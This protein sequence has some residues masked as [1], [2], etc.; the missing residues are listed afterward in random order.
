MR[1]TRAAERGERPQEER[2]HRLSH[3][4]T[5]ARVAAD[6]RD[7]DG[8]IMWNRR[9]SLDEALEV[10]GLPAGTPPQEALRVA[11]AQ[12]AELDA[13]AHDQADVLRMLNKAEFWLQE[14]E[15]AITGARVLIRVLLPDV[16]VEH[17]LVDGPSSSDWQEEILVVAPLWTKGHREPDRAH[18]ALAE[19]RTAASDRGLEWLPAEVE[20]SDGLR[21]ALALP[22]VAT[23]DLPPPLLHNAL[24]VRCS[25]E[26]AVVDLPRGDRWPFA[27]R[28]VKSGGQPDPHLV[29]LAD[30]Q[31]RAR[32]LREA[33]ARMAEERRQA[34]EVQARKKAERARLREQQEALL[35]HEGWPSGWTARQA[36]TWTAAGGDSTSARA[37]QSA[38][39]TPHE[40]STAAREHRSVADV[41]PGPAELHRAHGDDLSSLWTRDWPPVPPGTIL[42]ARRATA[43]GGRQRV[44]L[45]QAGDE[46]HLVIARL[47]ARGWSSTRRAVADPPLPK[48]RRWL[49]AAWGTYTSVTTFGGAFDADLLLD[50][51]V[52]PRQDTRSEDA[53]R[54]EDGDNAHLSEVA[55]E[56]DEWLQELLPESDAVIRWFEVDGRRLTLLPDDSGRLAKVLLDPDSDELAL[57]PV[58]AHL[59]WFSESGG[60]PISWNGGGELGFLQG[61]VLVDRVWGDV[62]PGAQLLVARNRAQLVAALVQ[63]SLC[64]DAEIAAALALEPLDPRG[65]LGPEARGEWDRLLEELTL[66]VSYFLPEDV[67]QSLRRVLARRG[68]RY[69]YVKR[70]LHDPRSGPGRHVLDAL[71]DVAESGVLG[72]I[73]HLD[74]DLSFAA[75]RTESAQH[76]YERESFSPDFLSRCLSVGLTR[77]DLAGWSEEGLSALL[78]AALHQGLDVSRLSAWMRRA[79]GDPDAVWA[80]WHRSAARWGEA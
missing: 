59:R 7:S 42:S 16:T 3:P 43:E 12:K 14:H 38:G 1:Y 56:Q 41:P 6:V 35:V 69:W 44:S 33:E 8:R 13:S 63:W 45:V 19:L 46:K 78:D 48:L 65:T 53:E 25:S 20:S 10:L 76:A 66:T 28:T 30:K 26:S 58:L 61:D 68:T 24:L 34:A 37:A 18:E 2:R 77:D 74:P 60:A 52:V 5:A 49:R 21:P 15:R 40:A 62:D 72:A 47:T 31:R 67:E 29:W 39:W 55:S 79:P 70:A 17:M 11:A 4:R 32:A 64:E 9:L 75:N 73:S 50:A 36:K 22:H 80:R 57:D 27:V 51:V 71:R 23:G 54:W